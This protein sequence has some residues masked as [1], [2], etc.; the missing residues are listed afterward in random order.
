MNSAHCHLIGTES[1]EILC[2]K[3]KVYLYVE[4]ITVYELYVIL[5]LVVITASA[6]LFFKWML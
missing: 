2:W 5:S 6:G 4:Q 1:L 3:K